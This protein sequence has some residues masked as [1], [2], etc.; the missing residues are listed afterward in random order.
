MDHYQPLIERFAIEGDVLSIKS[1]GN[2]LIN[3]TL[4]VETTKK[5]YIFQSI[6]N[7]VF[8][9]VDM[10]M[11]N[12]DQ[13]TSHLRS[14]GVTTLE[15]V[16][17]KDGRLYEEV[18]GSFYRGYLFIESSV[19]YEKPSSLEMV[20]QTGLGFGSFHKNLV[21]IDISHIGDVIKGFHD[22]RK[23]Y[24][25][26]VDIV[27]KNPVDRL[28]FCQDEVDFLLSRKLDYPVIVEGIKDGSVGLRITHNDPKINNI[29]FDK[30]TNQVKCVLDLDTVMLGSYLYDFGD[31]LRSLFTGDNE[32]NFDTRK[33][34]VDLD[35][36]RS[37]LDGYYQEMT[38]ALSSKELRLLP[39]SI[40]LITEELA[41]RFLGDFINGDKY[42]G[43]KYPTHNLVRARSQIALAKDIIK[44]YEELDDITGD[45]VLKYN[46]PKFVRV[47]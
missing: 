6:N 41:M 5:R 1:Y 9:D 25:D 31:C 16:K 36:Y 13:V 34:K 45:V 42:F 35:I 27:N 21:D 15:I 44:H 2:G 32:D 10:L 28:Y 7:N 33:L 40:L 24:H 38:G 47:D 20:R 39:F 8:P 43:I 3:K 37:F 12:I 30:D 46:F 22:T 19:C 14:K 23:R 26:F 29:A 4:L 11:N 18:D 17:T